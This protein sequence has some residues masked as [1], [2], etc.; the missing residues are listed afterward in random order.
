MRPGD[1]HMHEVDQVMVVKVTEG[2]HKPYR[3]TNGFYLRVGPNSQKMA[4]DKIAE[5]VERYGRVRFDER[6]RKDFDGTIDNDL[7]DQFFN[8]ADIKK[9]LQS[10][11]HIFQS[12]GLV[13][14]IDGINYFT[15]A[16]IL[17]FTTDP[18][19][20]FYLKPKSL[21]LPTMA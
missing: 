12:L 10:N 3:S 20:I 13:K 4:T 16:S 15:N 17:F 6:I 19:P 14:Q 5:Y 8:Q 11:T 18:L 1:R 7:V 21:A 9:P 2:T